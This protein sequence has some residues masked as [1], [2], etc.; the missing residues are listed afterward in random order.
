VL[1]PLVS[2]LYTTCPLGPYLRR[3]VLTFFYNSRL[4]LV[5]KQADNVRIYV[6]LKLSRNQHCP[7]KAV[8]FTCSE[9]VLVALVVHYV[10]RIR[11]II[12]SSMAFPAVPN[13][14]TLSH[15]RHD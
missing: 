13:F 15:K 2:K 14:S 4:Y 6:T 10:Q 8:I 12:L 11:R 5:L 3:S 9:R 1:S 7:G